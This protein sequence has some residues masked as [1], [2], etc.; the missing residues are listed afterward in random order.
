MT[1]FI[2]LLSLAGVPPLGG[3][4]AKLYIFAAVMKEGIVWLAALG[5]I[6]AVVS[7][8]YFLLVIK[9]VYLHDP[10]VTEP[11]KV[12][13]PAVAALYLINTVTV[14]LGIYPGPVTDWVMR[15]AEVFVS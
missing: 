2:G 9:R 6:M 10:V 7:M 1:L 11:I 12:P 15:I 14:I 3:F 4:I 5:V 13:A 8:Y